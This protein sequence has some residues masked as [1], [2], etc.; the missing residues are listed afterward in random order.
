MAARLISFFLLFV[1]ALTAVAD[2]SMSYRRLLP[3]E[4]GSN[5]R[6][7]GGYRTADG[8]TV[9]RGMLFRS[10]AMTGLTDADMA[11]LDG[12]GIKTIVDLRSNE[13]ISLYPNHWAAKHRIEVVTGDYSFAAMM[14][15]EES[16]ERPAMGELYPRL[17]ESIGPQIKNYFDEALGE[18]APMVVNCSAGQDRTGIVSAVMLLL[19]GVPE[20]TVIEDYLLSTDFRRPAI[21]DGGV[22]LAEAA[23]TNAFAA[24]MLEYRKAMPHPD[25]PNPLVTSDGVPYLAFVIER[26]RDEYGSVEAYAEKELGIDAQDLAALRRTYLR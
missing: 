25:R 1:F 5:F 21:E 11:Y 9:A 13:E 6:D 10:G 4:G 8:Q 26:I 18:G 16:G 12:F 2:L 14:S 19:L 23:K 15:G 24:M 22:D 20:P 17:L 3:L 7:L